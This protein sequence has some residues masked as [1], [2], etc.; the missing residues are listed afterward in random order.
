MSEPL[1]QLYAAASRP[2]RD[3]SEFRGW[4]VWIGV[5]SLW[6]ARRMRSSPPVILRAANLTEL[7]KAIRERS[8][9]AQSADPSAAWP[10]TERASWDH[11][12]PR[13]QP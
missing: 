5:N 10:S 3:W 12:P 8:G 4:H 2:L 13:W 9:S 7:P 1:L 11:G 6:Y